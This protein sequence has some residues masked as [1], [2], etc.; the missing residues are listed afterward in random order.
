MT[1]FLSKIFIK[2]KSQKSFDILYL[3]YKKNPVDL[4]IKYN[5][6][7]ILNILNKVHSCNGLWLLTFLVL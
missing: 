1:F 7:K 3:Y 5:L 2:K 4:G 6:F